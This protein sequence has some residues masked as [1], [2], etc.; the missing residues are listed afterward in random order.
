ML[1]TAPTALGEQAVA[2]CE[3]FLATAAAGPATTQTRY[4]TFIMLVY[5]VEPAV[6]TAASC[7]E[8]T[9]NAGIR[10]SHEFT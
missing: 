1:Q 4:S 9:S 2:S 3:G 10:I 5:F 6:A 8:S 7:V